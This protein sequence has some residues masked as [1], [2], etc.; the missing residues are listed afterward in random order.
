MTFFLLYK[1]K[2]PQ[3]L[4]PSLRQALRSFPYF[5]LNPWY[6]FNNFERSWLSFLVC[7]SLRGLRAAPAGG[8]LPGGGTL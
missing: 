8:V 5:I 4:T 2:N 6:F 7:R 3:H 1:H